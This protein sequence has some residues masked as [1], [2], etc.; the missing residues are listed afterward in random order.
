M[1]QSLQSNDPSLFTTEG[2][3]KE[4]FC[5]PKGECTGVITFETLWWK[6]T[7]KRTFQNWLPTT[8]PSGCWHC[9]ACN[10]FSTVSVL[11]Y[12]LYKAA[13]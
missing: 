1:T 9:M 2:H 10:K 13:T 12:L 4:D 5:L 7:I 11:V 8:P 6:A 3:Y